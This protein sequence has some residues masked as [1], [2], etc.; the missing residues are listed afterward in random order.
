MTTEFDS[1]YS[2]VAEAKATG[3]GEFI[4]HGAYT[5]MIKKVW[6]DKG[7]NGV[8]FKAELETVKSEPQDI[9]AGMTEPGEQVGPSNPNKVGSGPIY[10]VNLSK[11]GKEGASAFGN[12]KAFL[13]AA[14]GTPEAEFNSD[15]EK[16]KNFMKQ[17]TSA[18]NPLRGVLMTDRTFRKITQSGKNAG[19]PFTGHNWGHVPGQTA[20]SVKANRAMLD[21]KAAGEQ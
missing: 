1:I 9:A 17:A 18:A 7:Y 21:A 14:D 16:F 12:V 8:C 10:I 19:K 6:I 13:L 11:G 2:Q 20:E 3:G 5:F 15:P 4:R